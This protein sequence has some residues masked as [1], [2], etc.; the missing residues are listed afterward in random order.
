MWDKL[1][2]KKEYKDLYQPGRKPVLIDVPP[3][4]MFLIDGKGD[5]NEEGGEY[6]AAMSALY[7]VTFTLKMSKMGAWQPE[8]YFDYV[9]PPLEGFWKRADGDPDLMAAPKSSWL[10][11]SGLRCPE[12]CT[13]QVFDWALEECRRKKP[14]VD[15]SKLRVETV[16]EG[17]CVQCLH[18]G[19]YESE[20]ATMDQMLAFR[21]A[22]G[23]ADGHGP[24]RLHHEIYLGDPRKTPPEKWR[25]ILRLPVE[26]R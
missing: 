17:L 21:D 20:R 1:D 10:W 19:S 6:Q 11:T 23:L 14:E 15:T 2:Y 24:T 25:T 26:R 18:V 7:A 4:S 9:L 16:E 3:I 13:P 12:Y 5:P 22:Q 8:G